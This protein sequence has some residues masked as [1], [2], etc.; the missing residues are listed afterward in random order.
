MIN[1]S[2]RAQG[3]EQLN[4]LIQLAGALARFDS[5]GGFEILE[6]LIDQ[7]NDMADAAVVLNGFGQEY[8]KDGEMPLQNF[9]PLTQIANQMGQAFGRLAL[10]DFARARSD[11]ERIR[12]PEA[13]ISAYMAMAQQVINPPPLGR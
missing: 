12:R 4:A 6:P 13:R 3:Q 7:F 5:S 9:T 11:V 2:P 1:S 8:Y 10:S